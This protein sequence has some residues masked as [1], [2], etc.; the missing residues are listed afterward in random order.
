MTGFQ[1]RDHMIAGD[2]LGGVDGAAVAM[3]AMAKLRVVKP[4][5]DVAPV[6]GMQPQP[7]PPDMG[8]LRPRAVHQFLSPLSV[9]GALAVQR[10]RSPACTVISVVS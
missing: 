9:F 8:D 7:G 6:I 10:M 4:H 1:H 2:A 5:G 3:V